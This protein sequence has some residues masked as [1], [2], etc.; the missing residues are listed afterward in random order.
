M[1]KF[2][3]ELF[4]NCNSYKSYHTS[5]QVHITEAHYIVKL[6]KLRNSCGGWSHDIQSAMQKILQSKIQDC[7]HVPWNF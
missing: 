5:F 6:K 1:H 3:L 2:E 4:L 7:C